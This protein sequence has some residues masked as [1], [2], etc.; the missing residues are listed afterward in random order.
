MR[1]LRLS[2]AWLYALPAVFLGGGSALAHP[3]VFI[4]NR[5][6]FLF[7]GGRLAGFRTD[8]RFDEIFTEDMLLH[9]DADGDGSISAAESGAMGRETLRNLAPFRY[10]ARLAIDGTDMPDLAPSEFSARVE[11][12][13][14][15]FVLTFALPAALDP[16]RQTLRLEIS[17]REYYV[18]ILLAAD[19]PVTLLGE[20]SENCR[21]LMR[22]DPANAYYGGF[23]I[24]HAISL[25]CP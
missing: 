11:E 22:E 15:H 4:E 12:G 20:G 25:Q 2:L 9:Y 7:E 18:E 5:V 3:H 8:W 24:P 17:D 10:F 16:A 23:V 6:T 1:S 14:L 19:D 21:P 13:A